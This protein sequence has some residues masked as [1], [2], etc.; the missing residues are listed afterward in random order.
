MF[1]IVPEVEPYAWM[2]ARDVDCRKKSV[3]PYAG[4]LTFMLPFKR[5]KPSRHAVRIKLC[6][7]VADYDCE[8]MCLKLQREQRWR[9]TGDNNRI[10]GGIS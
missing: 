8:G 6:Q 9:T 1:R 10:L 2:F 3:P 5:E 4:N 7:G